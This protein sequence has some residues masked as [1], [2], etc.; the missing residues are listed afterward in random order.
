MAFYLEPD[1]SVIQQWSGKRSE[2]D[3]DETKVG[4]ACKLPLTCF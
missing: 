3:Y 4:S 1:A 2:C